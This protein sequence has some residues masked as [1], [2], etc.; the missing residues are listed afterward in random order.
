MAQS[1]ILPHTNTHAFLNWKKNSPSAELTTARRVMVEK[2]MAVGLISALNSLYHF[3]DK[4]WI[5]NR[6]GGE[7]DKL[8]LNTCESHPLLL[9]RVSEGVALVSAAGCC[10]EAP[11]IYDGGA[12]FDAQDSARIH[13]VWAD[14]HQSTLNAERKLTP[15]AVC[16]PATPLCVSF[17]A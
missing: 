16:A 6:V 1:I 7:N 8:D 13:W 12:R 2:I 11:F 9:P 3:L 14:S 10:P 17:P 5:A 4:I 15:L